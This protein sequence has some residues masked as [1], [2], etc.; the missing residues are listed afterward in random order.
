MVTFYDT[1]GAII[2]AASGSTMIKVLP[3]GKS[4]PFIIS[5][6]RPAGL[7]SHSL[8]AVGRRHRLSHRPN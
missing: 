4:S 8:R 2:G 6:S 5:L 1:A 7:A 3:P